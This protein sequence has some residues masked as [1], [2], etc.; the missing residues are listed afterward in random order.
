LIP[1]TTLRATG[2]LTAA[3]LVA[4]AADAQD[5]DTTRA[6]SGPPIRRIA[7]ASAVSTQT[8]GSLADVHELPGG[9]VL[10]NDGER[11]QLLL[12]D[13]TLALV[14]VV[15]DSVSETENTYGN[16][17]GTVIPYR[18][19]STVF[20]DPTSLALLILDPDAN[21]SRVRSVPRVQ[22][23]PWYTSRSGGFTRMGSDAR[24]RLVYRVNAQ[25]A[26]PARR[27]PRGVPYIPPQPDSAFV[28]T[29]DLE[30]RTVDTLGTI[31]IPKSDFIV[32]LRPTGGYDV[33][34]AINPLPMTDEWAVLPDG[35][36]AF[37]RG[38][39]YRVEYLGGDGKWTSSAKLPYDWQAMSD[40][41]KKQ[42]VDSVRS[43]LVAR[44]R[45]SYTTSV[46]RWV[47]QYGRKR[48]P[49]G[50]VAPGGY[51][52][53]Q[54]FGKDWALPQGV[55]FPGNYIFAC[56]E[57]EEPT[58]VG[59]TA[60]AD[61]ADEPTPTPMEMSRGGRGQGG[62][63]GRPSCIPAPVPNTNAPPA[64]RLREPGVVSAQLLPDF[65]PPFATGAVRADADGNL[66]IRTI[67]PRRIPGGPVYDIVNRAGV[68][69]DRLQLP[70]GYQIV[71]FG[72]GKV[73]YLAMREAGQVKLARVRLR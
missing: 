66:W 22:D 71:G 47:N 68:L 37:V 20:I 4:T 11:R 59:R 49:D 63:G 13:T 53:P 34:R 2:A 41:A 32:R 30:T 9:R 16:R 46:I 48:Y 26:R 45:T 62:A 36:V 21:V 58:M 39:D 52:P 18:G 3:V 6:A 23:V 17:A 27:P 8:F 65:R 15:L 51:R 42:L 25:P 43:A 67:P 73:V 60:D 61:D 28:V 31:R 19:D 56:A 38:I 29:V 5:V 1:T 24:G 70:A 64:P 7:T 55:S 10:V 69:V 33:D 40:E 14:R 35:A 54:G 72:K 44:A 12:L 50:F 57:G